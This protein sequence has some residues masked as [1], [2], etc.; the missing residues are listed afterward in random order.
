LGILPGDSKGEGSGIIERWSPGERQALGIRIEKILD[1]GSTIII[2]EKAW[3]R[4]IHDYLKTE[5]GEREIDLPEMWR[6]W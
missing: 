3:R 1:N 2:G 6:N 4:E 5:N